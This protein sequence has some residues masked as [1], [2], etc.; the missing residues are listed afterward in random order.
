M[1]IQVHCFLCLLQCCIIIIGIIAMFISVLVYPPLPQGCN[2]RY[3]RQNDLFLYKISNLYLS[4]YYVR[5]PSVEWVLSFIF[6]T[7]FFMI[8]VQLFG[9][10][11]IIQEKE[12]CMMSVHVSKPNYKLKNT[13]IMCI[14]Y[15]WYMFE[16]FKKFA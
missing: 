2:H 8:I 1:N 4:Q 15:M 14:D 7:A 10:M 6:A 3:P 11:I 12:H 13:F 9:W 5:L 16:K